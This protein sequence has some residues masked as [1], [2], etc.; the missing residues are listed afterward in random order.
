[1][2]KKQKKVLII[3]CFAVFALVI[4]VMTYKGVFADIVKDIKPKKLANE[5]EAAEKHDKYGSEIVVNSN[6]MEYTDNRPNVS[7][8]SGDVCFEFDLKPGYYYELY[9]GYNAYS[10]TDNVSSGVENSSCS[11]DSKFNCI[12]DSIIVSNNYYPMLSG[13]SKRFGWRSVDC[14]ALKGMDCRVQENDTKRNFCVTL[15]SDQ[16]VDLYFSLAVSDWYEDDYGN[17][18]MPYL[19]LGRSIYW[20]QWTFNIPPKLSTVIV[21]EFDNP[22]K[23]L[24]N[25]YI[26]QV[27]GTDLTELQAAV[28]YCFQDKVSFDIGYDNLENTLNNFMRYLNTKNV[29]LEFETSPNVLAVDSTTISS[30]LKCDPFASSNSNSYSYTKSEKYSINDNTYNYYINNGQSISSKV[31]CESI[32]QEVVTVTYGPPVAVNAGSC[33]ESEVTV[34]SNVE[35]KSKVNFAPPKSPTVTSMKIPS[36]YCGS[37]NNGWG[38]YESQ[39][40]PSDDFDSC[41]NQ[42]DNGEYSQACIDSCYSRVYG[43][44]TDESDSFVLGDLSNNSLALS[45]EN[46]AGFSIRRLANDSCPV[47]GNYSDLNSLVNAV[48]NYMYDENGLLRWRGHFYR[49]SSNSNKVRWAGDAGCHWNQYAPYYY[50]NAK[51]LR[52]TVGSDTTSWNAGIWSAYSYDNHVYKPDTWGFKRQVDSGG[53]NQYCYYYNYDNSSFGKPMEVSN[54]EFDAALDDYNDVVTQCKT[55]TICDENLAKFTISVANDNNPDG[56]SYEN[57]DGSSGKVIQACD[58]SSSPGD[59]QFKSSSCFSWYADHNQLTGAVSGDTLIFKDL[60]SYCRMKD[61]SKDDYFTKVSFPGTWENN[62]NSTYVYKEPEEEI[63]Y[64]KHEN[65]YCLSRGFGNINSAWWNWKQ[66]ADTDDQELKAEAQS[67][68]D[69]NSIFYNVLTNINDF[70]K[71]KWNFDVACFFATKKNPNVC[72]PSDPNYPTC[73]PKTTEDCPEDNP[74]CNS[75]CGEVELDNFK[76]RAASLKNLFVGANIEGVDLTLS[77]FKNTSLIRL[78]DSNNNDDNYLRATRL[79]RYN[80]DYKATDLSLTD[81]A[82]APTAA[83]AMIQNMGDDVYSKEEELDYSITITPVQMRAIRNYSSD[84]TED[85]YASSYTNWTG[86]FTKDTNNGINFYKSA[87]L[88]DTTYVT[89]NKLPNGVGCNNLISGGCNLDYSGYA[90]NA[91]YIPGIIF[92]NQKAFKNAG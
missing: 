22:Y 92:S 6:G 87:L 50:R 65:Q 72:G 68:V 66:F 47:A 54:D 63:F 15:S 2:G 26:S 51:V 41:V 52:R 88:R 4:S 55:S 19:A 78:E 24:C 32:C 5:N 27:S 23:E 89:T 42:C 35:C 81:Y 85:K 17:K 9:Y 16:E 33:F 67:K 53:C 11:S 12:N 45:Y 64:K 91:E 14:T 31:A 38:I 60:D 48:Y 1:M 3:S 37:N 44:S 75:S 82:V 62:K 28:P 30:V 43:D 79:T 10:D 76:S 29:S 21:R 58:N 49:D 71:Y 69:V 25:S 83:I 34:K 36:I 73:K 70:G 8:G 56:S 7:G 74:C 86:T 40:G 90:R 77:K 39:A 20:Q 80:W 57:P 84:T 61:E 18:Y 13:V 59:G 46:K